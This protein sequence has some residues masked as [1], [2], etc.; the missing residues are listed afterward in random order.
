VGARVGRGHERGRQ[1]AAMCGAIMKLACVCSGEALVVVAE[2]NN[3]LHLLGHALACVHMVPTLK[4][5]KW[6]H[7]LMHMVQV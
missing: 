4:T 2:E 5:V 6:L 1:H 7:A 3:K